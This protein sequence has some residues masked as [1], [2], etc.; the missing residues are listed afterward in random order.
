MMGDRQRRRDRRPPRPA[1]RGAEAGGSAHEPCP[2]AD[3][4]G[5]GA[6]AADRTP[7]PGPTG[8]L[9]G[10]TAPSATPTTTRAA[11]T[12]SCTPARAA[13]A[14]SSRRSRATAAARLAPGQG[15]PYPGTRPA[16]RRPRRRH[17]PA[18]RRPAAGVRL[19]A[20]HAPGRGGAARRPGPRR[21]G[22]RCAARP[23]A[24][25]SPARPA[26]EADSPPRAERAGAERVPVALPQP[27][28]DRRAAQ[29]VPRPWPAASRDGGSGREHLEA[30]AWR[31][32]ARTRMP[33]GPTPPVPVR[34][35]SRVGGRETEF[36]LEIVAAERSGRGVAG[37]ASIRSRCA[38]RLAWPAWSN[39]RP[40]SP[41][42]R[43]TPGCGRSS[44]RIGRRA[45][46]G[47]AG[48]SAACSGIGTA[49]R[50][51]WIRTVGC[52]RVTRRRAVVGR[53]GFEVR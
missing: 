1:S 39:T 44:M 49:T 6:W 18:A 20:R 41:T 29:F 11:S 46:A 50:A 14:R 8:A 32:G 4:G 36:R 33:F 45:V 48:A 30:R 21:G 15:E 9:P 35:F 38:D 23:A 28:G 31:A 40:S 25:P 52:R 22:G 47:A 27:A 43:R 26:A 16:R 24:A 51:R 37:C 10:R 19:V 13:S 3:G 7:G 42:A 5:S 12:A 17:P 34:V 53:F 2:S